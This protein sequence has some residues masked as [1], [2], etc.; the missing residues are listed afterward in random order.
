MSNYDVILTRVRYELDLYSQ[1]PRLEM[2]DA[3]ANLEL[4]LDETMQLCY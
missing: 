3:A 1:Q 4:G 2:L